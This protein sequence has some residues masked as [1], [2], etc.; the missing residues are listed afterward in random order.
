DET[1]LADASL[2][3]YFGTVKTKQLGFVITAEEAAWASNTMMPSLNAAGADAATRHGWSYVGGIRDPFLTHG[4]CAEE[5]WVVRYTESIA[6]QGNRDGTLHPNAPGHELYW[7][8]I[9]SGLVADLYAGGE[10]RRPREPS[11]Q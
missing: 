11:G 9:A 2:T 6:R 10:P 7:Q 3:D 1:M 5:H 4:Y 8:R